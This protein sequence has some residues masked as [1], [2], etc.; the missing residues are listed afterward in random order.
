MLKMQI[1]VSQKLSNGGKS[2]LN[3]DRIVSFQNNDSHKMQIC[4]ITEMA[5]KLS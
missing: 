5:L 1:H 2:E 4:H 3:I